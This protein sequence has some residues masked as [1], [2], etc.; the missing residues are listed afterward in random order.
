[1]WLW[2][3]SC[4]RVYGFLDR[5]QALFQKF[6]CAF[7]R[8]V[9]RPP[10]RNF[11]A[12]KTGDKQTIFDFLYRDFKF[13][14]HTSSI[15]AKREAH[16]R[17]RKLFSERFL[18]KMLTKRARRGIAAVVVSRWLSSTYAGPPRKSLTIKHLRRSRPSKKRANVKLARRLLTSCGRFPSGDSARHE[19]VQRVWLAVFS[20]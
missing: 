14:F 7:D 19:N 16:K 13:N 17:I 11:F 5:L 4:D 12:V 8:L 1:M 9:N 2:L 20:I 10:V 6:F 15:A 18:R 3:L